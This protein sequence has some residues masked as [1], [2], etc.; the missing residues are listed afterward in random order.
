MKTATIPAI[1]VQP[2]LREQVES[3]LHEGETLSEFVEQSVRSAL[4][5]RRDQSEFIA[6]GMA[7]LNA[8]RQTNDY[9]DSAIVIDGLQRKLD[10]AKAN[11]A[12]RRK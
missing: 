2:A 6:R 7:S 11:L 9:V 4:Q 3:S 5:R 8:A 1:R 12:K 10:A